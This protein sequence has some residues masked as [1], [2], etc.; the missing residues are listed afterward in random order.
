MSDA[1]TTE[2]KAHK[3]WS[4]G[5]IIELQGKYC[6]GVAHGDAEYLVQLFSEDGVFDARLRDIGFHQGHEALRAYFTKYTP[7]NMR[8]PMIHNTIITEFTGT[9]ATATCTNE[10]LSRKGDDY[11]TFPGMYEDKFRLEGDAWKFTSRRLLGFKFVQLDEGLVT[12][13]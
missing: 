13:K 9:E 3:A 4:R 1:L 7:P 2:Q 8:F 12:I 5:E 6:W 11:V 10:V